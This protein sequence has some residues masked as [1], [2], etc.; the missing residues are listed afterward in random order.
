MLRARKIALPS[1]ARSL[2][3]RLLLLTIG[4]VMLAEILI[5]APSVA[6]YRLDWLRERAAS[7]HLA[8]L[9]LEAAPAE[10]LG[11]HLKADL[12][13]RTGAYAVVLTR[14]D[15]R[16]MLHAEPPPPVDVKVVLGEGD[17]LDHVR[18]AFAT[19][20]R[21]GDPTLRL[22]EQIGRAHV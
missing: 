6:N 13:H 16:L 4:F 1:F 8:I 15:R 10:T 7:A 19:M 14:P 21:G 18:D 2:S 12:L 17:L 11:E 9:A 3:A 5:Y 20:L 22:I